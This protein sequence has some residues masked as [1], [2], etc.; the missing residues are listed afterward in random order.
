MEKENNKLKLTKSMIV[1]FRP[2]WT[3]RGTAKHIEEDLPGF[4]FSGPGWYFIGDD[5]ILIVPSAKTDTPWKN[6]WKKE[7]VFTYF[8]WN[9]RD[10]EGAFHAICLAPVRRQPEEK[11]EDK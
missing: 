7:A 4:K 11:K 1:D 5:S 10:A 2:D 3:S 8:V 9:D 6:T